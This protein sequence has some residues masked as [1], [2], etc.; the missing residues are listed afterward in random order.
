[1]PELPDIELYLHALRARVV[2]EW[3][4][5]VQLANAFLLRTVDPP[6]NA[7]FGRSVTAMHR[8][9]KRIVFQLDGEIFLA[10]H[11][12][13]AGRLQWKAR[14]LEGKKRAGLAT[15]YF[16]SGE[17]TLTEA[18]KKRRAS[19]HVLRDAAALRKHDPGGLE[20]LDC[21]QQ[22][23]AARLVLE[24][25]TVKRALCD[26]TLFSGIGN[27]YSD[28]ILHAARLSPFKLTR[29][30]TP[31]ET[32]GLFEAVQLTLQTWR[33]RLI[34]QAGDRF[35]AKVTA[36]RTEMAV[37][38]KYGEPCP[39]CTTGVQRIVYAQ[40][41]TNYCP[42]CQTDGRL[43]RDR[44]LSRLLKSDWPKTP[45]ELEERRR[46]EPSEAD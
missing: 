35:P 11:L 44:A 45:E 39:R 30:L 28:E 46:G 3:L 9:G 6:L 33:D 1:V 15:F 23:F 22:E 27:A 32:T 10:L 34:Q 14:R 37:H 5:D 4:E 38:G 17:L 19:L 42:A 41:E 12:M 26:P 8:L 21:S 40:N 29:D 16:S 43:L 31:A 18:G 25:H 2:G 24:N 13:V 7:A 20:V 36:F